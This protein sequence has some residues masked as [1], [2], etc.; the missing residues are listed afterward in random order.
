MDRPMR[1]RRSD[2]VSDHLDHDLVGVWSVLYGKNSI[3]VDGNRVVIDASTGEYLDDSDGDTMIDCRTCDVFDLDV[4]V[5]V[6]FV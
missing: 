5:E 1:T 6:D 4:D 3:T 2:K